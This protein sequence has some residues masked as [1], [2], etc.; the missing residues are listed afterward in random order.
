[1]TFWHKFAREILGIFG[2]TGNESPR[3]VADTF[4]AALGGFGAIVLLIYAGEKHPSTRLHEAAIVS[5]IVI[6]VGI[7]LAKNRLA[8]ILAI[9]AFIGLRG[10]VAFALYGYWP[11]LAFA[12]VVSV[13]VW[14]GIRFLPKT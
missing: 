11:G 14:L 13:G 9:A 5:L 8:V 2:L 6:V 12:V 3:L 7:L 10:V 1:M 4:L